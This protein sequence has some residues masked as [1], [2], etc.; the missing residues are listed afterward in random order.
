MLELNESN[1]KKEISKGFSVVDFWAEWCGPCKIIA[2][3]FESLAPEFKGVKFA[4]LN[5][6]EEQR[7]ASAF[8]VQSIPTLIIFKDGKEVDRL[9]G[10]QSKPMLK[11]KIQA[12][13][14]D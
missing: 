9:V 4:K 14:K 2:P 1:F 6:D 12:L 11:A 3:V 7:L 10:F 5:V 8:S 13:V